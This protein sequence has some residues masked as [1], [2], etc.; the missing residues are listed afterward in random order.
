[1]AFAVIVFFLLGS[2]PGWHEEVDEGT[3]SLIEIKPFPSRAVTQI[4]IACIAISALLTL[5]A[6]LWQH[7]GSAASG[8][9]VSSTTYDAVTADVGAAAM[10]LG[11]TG[12]AL[13]VLL[14][15]GIVQI[16]ISISLLDKLTEE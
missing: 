3:D 2:F 5:I 6:V 13:M 4:A 15:A 11:W 1:M 14:V 12:V 8:A 16:Q 10:A 9:M 7:V